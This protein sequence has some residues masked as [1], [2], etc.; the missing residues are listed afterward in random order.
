[1]W[2]LNPGSLLGQSVLLTP[3]LL[4]LQPRFLTVYLLKLFS[5]W[6]QHSEERSWWECFTVKWQH[7]AL[8]L[9]FSSLSVCVVTRSSGNGHPVTALQWERLSLTEGFP[10]NASLWSTGRG[11]DRLYP[12]TS[13]VL[14]CKVDDLSW[15][16]KTQG[17]I[18]RQ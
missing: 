6:G 2:G 9:M 11:C 18:P 4:S 1:M 10:D 5:E 13:I 17:K 16:S 15:I 8:L 14:A 7:V 3:E 12:L